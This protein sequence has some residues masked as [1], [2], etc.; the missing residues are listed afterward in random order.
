MQKVATQWLLSQCL[1]TDLN[2]SFL[3]RSKTITAWKLIPHRSKISKNWNPPW[4]VPLHRFFK[5]WFSLIKHNGKPLHDRKWLVKQSLEDISRASLDVSGCSWASRGS[6][7]IFGD[8]WWPLGVFGGLFL[9]YMR[10]FGF[11]ILLETFQFS[12]PTRDFWFSYL[13]WNFLS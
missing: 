7:G 1:R 4:W 13:T 6:L 10:L 9:S 12:Y 5:N 8:F 11:L 3:P 2:K